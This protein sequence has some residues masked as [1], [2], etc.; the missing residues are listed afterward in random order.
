MVH[1]EWTFWRQETEEEEE[2]VKKEL[3][4]LI[5]AGYKW[6]VNK[7]QKKVEHENLIIREKW[8]SVR[9][10]GI[11]DGDDDN[12]VDRCSLSAILANNFFQSCCSKSL[13]FYSLPS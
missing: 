6:E 9:A 11:D 13:F 1:Y 2:E 4:L 10:D 8:L 5:K 3:Y 12:D 7:K